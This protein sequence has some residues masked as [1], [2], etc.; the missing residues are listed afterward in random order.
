MTPRSLFNIIL[1][2]LGLFFLRESILES[3]QFISQLLYFIRSGF[4]LDAAAISLI[5]L[6]FVFFYGLVCYQLLF[7]TN[8]IV[9]W[10]KLDKGFQEEQFSFNISATLVLTIG[11]MVIAG[12]ILVNEVPNFC[13]QFYQ[14]FD[15]RR[16]NRQI[17]KPDLTF[18]ILSGCKIVIAT[19]LIGERDS[20]I[21][22]VIKRNESK[23]E[24][25]AENDPAS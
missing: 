7:S 9:D 4:T 3:F 23:T 22:Y 17:E 14:Y 13:R 15:A 21:A 10:L 5:I 11:L 18:M 25:G 19:L 1:K 12:I 20:I 2:V 16:T 6:L 8:R 24:E